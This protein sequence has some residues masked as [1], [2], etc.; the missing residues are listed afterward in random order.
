MLLVVLTQYVCPRSLTPPSA[1]RCDLGGNWRS[2][3]LIEPSSAPS[4]PR[5]RKATRRHVPQHWLLVSARFSFWC[6]LPAEGT[7]RV[8]SKAF[9]ALSRLRAN[10][11]MSRRIASSR[12]RRIG[13]RSDELSRD[14]HLCKIFDTVPVINDFSIEIVEQTLCCLVGPN[15]AGKT[16]RWI[17]HG[18]QNP[19]PGKSRFANDRYYRP[20]RAIRL[21][22]SESGESFRSGVF[23]DLSVRQILRSLQRSTNR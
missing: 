19:P 17:D 22:V 12:S 11:T 14:Q 10:G 18:R 7:G 23:R 21:L 20:R 9:S 8:C 2:A 6:P 13:N 16:T 4:H 3:A 1:C 5:A 15:G